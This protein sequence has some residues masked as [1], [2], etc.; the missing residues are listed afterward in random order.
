MFYAFLIQIFITKHFILER[1]SIYVAFFSLTALPET[2]NAPC[3]PSQ[4]AR[5][6]ILMVVCFAYFLFAASQNFH[7][8]YPY[9]GIWDKALAA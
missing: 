3:K 1:L 7:G 6:V 2:V 9:R 4:Q 5:T 8:V